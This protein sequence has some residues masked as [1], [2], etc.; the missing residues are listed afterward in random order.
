MTRIRFNQAKH[1]SAITNNLTTNKAHQF[2]LDDNDNIDMKEEKENT[3]FLSG[4]NQITI[5]D[6]RQCR[7]YV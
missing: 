5:K 1:Q 7:S 3:E 2:Y 4:F 6:Q